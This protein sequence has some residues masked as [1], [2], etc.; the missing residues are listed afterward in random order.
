LPALPSP[1]RTGRRTGLDRVHYDY[2]IGPSPRFQ[3]FRG[4]PSARLG[5]DSK[6]SQAPSHQRSGAVVAS[7]RIPATDDPHE[8][9]AVRLGSLGLGLLHREF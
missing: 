4:F 3:Q 2:V 6:V 8:S 5:C 7:L 9:D 1:H